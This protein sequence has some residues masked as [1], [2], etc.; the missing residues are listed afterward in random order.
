MRI[1][2]LGDRPW[3]FVDSSALPATRFI[4]TNSAFWQVAGSAAEVADRIRASCADVVVYQSGPGDWAGDL[5][6]GGYRLL[7]GM[8][9][10]T[11]LRSQSAGSCA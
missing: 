11:Y 1:V 5:Q 2:V 4:A 7:E 9:W 8:P 10:P 6:A 3:L